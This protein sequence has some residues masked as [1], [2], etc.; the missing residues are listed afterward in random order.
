M[1][2]ERMKSI[3]GDY[4]IYHP[5]ESLLKDLVLALHPLYELYGSDIVLELVTDYLNQKDNAHERI[6]CS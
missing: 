4:E 2:I 3:L 1:T 5:P 6:N